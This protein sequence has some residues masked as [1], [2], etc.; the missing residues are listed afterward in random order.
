[1]RLLARSLLAC[2]GMLMLGGVAMWLVQQTELADRLMGW[3]L[4]VSPSLPTWFSLEHFLTVLLVC[5]VLLIWVVVSVAAGMLVWMRQKVHRA[6]SLQT[7]QATAVDRAVERLRTDVQREYERL[8]GLSATLTQRLDKQVLIQNLLQAASQVTSLP[9]ADSAVGLWVLDF[10]TD[11]MRFEM[12]ARC[13]ESLFTKHEFELHEPPFQQFLTQAHGLCFRQWQDGFPHVVPEKTSTL[14]GANGLLVI[15]LIIE[16][17]VLGC[18]VIFCHPDVVDSYDRQQAFF[19]AVWGQ[20]ALALSIAIQGEL[21]ILDRLT[22]MVNRAYFTKRLLQEV[23]RSNRY[24]LPLGMLMIDI[25][26]F[27]SVNDTLGHPQGDAVLKL[28]AKLIKGSVRAID[29]V[30]RYGGEEFI[31]LLPETG[32]AEEEERGSSGIGIVAERIRKS[33]EEEFRGLQKPLT[34]TVSI[35]AVV[36][37]M[38][39]HEG[40]IESQELIRLA[41]EQLYKAKSSGKNRVCIYQS[42]HPSSVTL[43]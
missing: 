5:A 15:P 24:K 39:D 40:K 8:I 4:D 26:N 32:L 23:E 37:G 42:E 13:D 9:Q 27:K 33:V 6:Q 21:A 31:V 3:F 41:D 17:T 29:L 10:E 18:L 36:G 19:N 38:Q 43:S 34:I 1:M 14:G 7:A 12:G 20:L 25:D 16:R 11:R 30:G 22:G 35:G 28:V 2:L